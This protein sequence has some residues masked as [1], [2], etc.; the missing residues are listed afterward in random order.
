[1]GSYLRTF[2]LD[3]AL[4]AGAAVLSGIATMAFLGLLFK[5]REVGHV[6]IALDAKSLYGLPIGMLPSSYNLVTFDLATEFIA[7]SKDNY[8]NIFQTDKF[9]EGIRLEVS[10]QCDVAL[11]TN[12]SKKMVPITLP[13]CVFGQPYKL[14]VSYDANGTFHSSVNER[15]LKPYQL[16]RLTPSF[17]AFVF[18]NGFNGERP[19]YGE[20]TTF[21]FKAKLYKRDRLLV[22]AI[23][24]LS[25]V[26]LAG[27]FYIF[28]WIFGRN[29]SVVKGPEDHR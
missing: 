29:F 15:Q 2:G 18:K 24:F 25:A 27:T 5:H 16:S 22:G 13:R 19:F 11:L 8:Q 14:S 10:P 17:R 3:L 28:V 23:V 9:N 21:D 26:C 6:H 4:L 1:M 12:S 20:V 7:L